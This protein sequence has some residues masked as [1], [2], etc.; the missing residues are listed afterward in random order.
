M[1]F[2]LFNLKEGDIMKERV[3]KK[4]KILRKK[5]F[6]F[7]LL[8]FFTLT[9]SFLVLNL[10]LS[11]YQKLNSNKEIVNLISETIIED[12]DESL[13]EINNISRKVF[14]EEEFFSTYD[15]TYL[16]S[17]NE[18]MTY[19]LNGKFEEYRTELIRGM[20]F[21]SNL[22]DET[23]IYSGAFNDLFYQDS[24]HY[25]IMINFIKDKSTTE[26]YKGGKMFL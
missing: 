8:I 23:I 14:L 13:N 12:F 1:R 24:P 26:E 5:E 20:G 16:S 9:I 19:Y 25:K 3:L 15:K 6:L 17:D 4:T 18:E 22:N 21:I 10:S 11:Y 7:I 2:S